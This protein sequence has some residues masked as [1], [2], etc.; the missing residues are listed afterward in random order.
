MT[1][2]GTNTA[3]IVGVGAHLPPNTVSNHELV[4]R[5][6][7][8]D[9][10][11]RSRTGIARRHVISPGTTTAD[12]AV[13]AGGR[14]LKSAGLDRVDAVVLATTTPDRPCPATAPEVASRLG[15]TGVA[16]FDVSAVCTGFLYG[17]ATGAG[18]IAAGTA[19]H[20]LV[21]A[22]EAFTTLIDP[23]DRTT[24][25]IFGDGAGAVVLRA[26]TPDE[27]GAVGRTLLGSDGENADLVA[28]GTRGA[29]RRVEG[30]LPRE[31]RYFRMAGRQV[32]RH[33]VTRM[34]TVCADA[35]A[36]ADWTARD[37]DLL[38]AHQANGRITSAVA[39]FVGI[40]PERRASN[41]ERVGNTAGASV[42]ILLADAAADGTLRPGHRVLLTAFGGGLTWGATTL[43]WPDVSPV[44]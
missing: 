26:G 43:V 33:A 36:A 19:E 28:V 1:R 41:I 44:I 11:I 10:W 9:D 4:E 31:E 32:F 42:P 29:A 40:P 17:L 6:D 34:S 18:L 16:A 23:D 7:T 12:L 5:L 14:A 13:E 22:A 3:V 27:P 2:A 39:D 20:V 37:V 21:I 15:M 25:P 30:P 38:V 8:T 24:A 35:L